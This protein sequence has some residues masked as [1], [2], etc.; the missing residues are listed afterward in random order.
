MALAGMGGGIIHHNIPDK[1]TL[2]M[3][4]MPFIKNGG[5]FIPG[6]TQHELGKELF[7]MLTMMGSPERI[8][9]ACKVVWVTPN[10][11]QNS[12]TPGIGVQFSDVDQ[13]QTRTKIEAYLAG[14]VESDRPTYTL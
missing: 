2:Y 4:Y 6:H 12:R 3:S 5:L 10:G 11:A 14:A 7:L 13:G 8:A 1:Q 9:V